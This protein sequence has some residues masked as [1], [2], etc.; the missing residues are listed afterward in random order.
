MEYVR[1]VLDHQDRDPAV[2]SFRKGDLIRVLPADHYVQ[3]GW[4]YGTLGDR[5]G[6]FPCEFVEP[7][8]REEFLSAQTMVSLFISFLMVTSCSTFSRILGWFVGLLKGTSFATHTYY[9]KH[10]L[11]NLIAS[12]NVTG[13]YCCKIRL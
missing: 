3:K 2:L 10:Y 5:R 6:V 13:F 4:L 8:S 7:L 11:L 1:G 12:L 9:K